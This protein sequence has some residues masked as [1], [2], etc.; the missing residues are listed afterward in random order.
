MNFLNVI[1][2]EAVKF[3]EKFIGNKALYEI[4]IQSSIKSTLTEA[5]NNIP[6]DLSKT[7]EEK[8]EIYYKVF[9]ETCE[10]VLNN[11]FFNTYSNYV[12]QKN[13]ELKIV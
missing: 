13:K 8:I 5:L 1:E 3:C 6:G 4:N 12:Y 10:E 7:A 11:I 9:D 2:K